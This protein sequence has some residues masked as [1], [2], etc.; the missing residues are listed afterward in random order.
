MITHIHTNA[1]NGPASEIDPVIADA[2][3]SIFGQ[4]HKP[5]WKECYTKVRRLARL[6]NDP[7][8]EPRIGIITVTDHLNQKSHTLQKDALKLAAANPRLAIC[9]EISCVDIDL[10]GKY[11]RSPE[12]LVYGRPEPVPGPFGPYFGLSQDMLDDMFQRCRA[13]GMQELQTGKVL[14]YCEN[15][16][17]A[18]ALAHPLD[19][20]E[21][22]LEPIL[23]LVS[24]SK[25]VEVVNGGFP[26]STSKYL[27]GFLRFQVRLAQGWRIPDD[28]ITRFPLA[29]RL[30]GKIIREN[31]NPP[32]P[33]GGSDAHSHNFSRVVIVF[34]TQSLQP[35]AGDLFKTMIDYSTTELMDDEIFKIEGRPGSS[36][37]VLDD[38]LRI[39]ARNIW[40]GRRKYF[41]IPTKTL[42]LMTETRRVVAQELGK[43]ARRR[44]ELLRYAQKELPLSR[45]LASMIPPTK[46]NADESGGYEASRFVDGRM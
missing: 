41:R 18:Y 40:E 45:I 27:D 9:G 30:V 12:V 33:W 17:L 4:D 1:S 39:V 34:R 13:P 15:N 21:L 2:L 35:T 44:A 38:V 6:L 37:S 10:D 31:R 29:G 20:Q 43:R 24:R 8:T 22:S 5:E 3:R 19:G 14:D 46:E 25:F 11:R 26:A 7:W 16:G 36:I 28:M 23:G 32:H 42:A